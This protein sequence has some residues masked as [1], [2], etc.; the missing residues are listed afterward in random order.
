MWCYVLSLNKHGLYPEDLNVTKTQI[1]AAVDKLNDIKTPGMRNQVMERRQVK[2]W[3]TFKRQCLYN[4]LSSTR[5]FSGNLR[6]T[7]DLTKQ[8]ARITNLDRLPE[9]NSL[10]AMHVLRDAWDDVDLY[11]NEAQFMKRASQWSYYILLLLVVLIAIF[12]TYSINLPD[13]LSESQLSII[14]IALSLGNSFVSA[15]I[16]YFK[17]VNKW[18]QLR[19]AATSLESEIWRFRTRS[20]KYCLTRGDNM[21][22]AEAHLHSVVDSTR[23]HVVKSATISDTGFFATIEMF[24]QTKNPTQFRH[25]QYEGALISGTHGKANINIQKLDDKDDHHSPLGPDEYLRHRVKP[26]LDMYQSRLPWYNMKRTMV[27]LVIF[28]CTLACTILAFAAL[29]E[30]STVQ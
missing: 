24:G 19:S 20:G 14:I 12:V 13:Q 16:Q 2:L 8:L 28:L 1:I 11:T 9:C 23:Q 18:Q 5:L 25:G 15:S 6:D 17:P 30:W 4:T 22:D 7:A 10:A 26:M 21:A 3:P 29:S 27:T